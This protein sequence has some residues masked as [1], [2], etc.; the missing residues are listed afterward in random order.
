M[1]DYCIIG[2]G[3]SGSTIANLLRKKSTVHVF[4]KAKGVGGRSSFK[5]Y[6]NNIG[7]D[8]GL[9]YL[10]PKSAEFKKFTK[11]LI[12]Q[13]VL[14][15]WN[16]DH[17]FLNNNVKQDKKHIKLIGVKG[18][19]EISKYFLKK[20]N[21]TL[22]SELI[23]ISR[24]KGVWNLIFEDKKIQSKNLILTAPFLQSKKLLK[25]FVKTQLFKHKV[26]MNS[27]LT[28][29]LMTNKTNNKASSYF[30]NDE[31][32]GWISNEN[33]KRRFKCNK[34]LWVLQSTFKYGDKHTD[35][36]RNKRKY[37]ISILIDKFKKLTGI[38][39]KK[40]YFSHIHGWK[41]ASNSKAINVK[42]YW[43]KGCGLGICADWFGGPRL[44]NG[45]LSANDLYA[46]IIKR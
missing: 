28:V 33:S 40:I 46:K 4:D 20:N 15:K 17:K 6:K 26:K 39:I 7:F 43:D 9:Q 42:S 30:T 14:K 38:K 29:L 10:S 44:E 19:N 23:S 31:T 35:N 2:S 5:R 36:Y 13:K 34:D 11:K 18:N 8:H 22:N 27:N 37:Y 25:K 21:Y 3:I 12:K 16:G 1:I 24:Y 32:L 45:W 41:Y